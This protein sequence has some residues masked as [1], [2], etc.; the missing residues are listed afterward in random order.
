M[1]VTADDRA[2]V[3]P[4]WFGPGTWIQVVFMAIAFTAF[5]PYPSSGRGWALRV[6][7]ALVGGFGIAMTDVWANRRQDR[8]RLAEL[9]LA[10]A[11]RP[12]P[13]NVLSG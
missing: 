7:F 6:V 12:M 4:R 3:R 5:P 13:R 1:N 2:D 8:K 9:A 10:A 11:A